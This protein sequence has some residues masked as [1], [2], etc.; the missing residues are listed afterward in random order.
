MDAILDFAAGDRIDLSAIDAITGG[1][2][3]AFAFIGGGAFSSTAGELHVTGA[4]A[5][6]TLE[7]DTNGDGVADFAVAIT[8]PGGH[9]F[10]ALDFVL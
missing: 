1:A 8:T 2:N 9:V 10:T 7:G 5:N 3:N 4:G 6:W